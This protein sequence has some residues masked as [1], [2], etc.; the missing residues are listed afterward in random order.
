MPTIHRKMTGKYIKLYT[1]TL[2][3][4][5]ALNNILEDLK[6][7]FCT[8]APKN[9]RPIEVVIKG[10][11][12]D[13]NTSDIHSDLLDLRF[14]VNK[15]TQVTCNITKQLLPVF[16]ISLPRNLTNAKIFELKKLSFLSITVEGFESR[17]TT[18]CNQFNHTAEH[19]HLTPKCLKCGNE[20]QTRDCQIKRVDTPFCINCQ[21][22]GHMA[23]YTKCPLF[24]KPRK[25]ANI[26]TNYTNIV[27]SLVRPNT[28]YAQITHQTQIPDNRWHDCYRNTISKRN[29]HLDSH[30]HA[31]Q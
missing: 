19:C 1:D 20:H 6:Y 21:A 18:Q 4:Y 14:T 2:L 24:P 3:Q 28:S 27:N 11:P 15:V 16:T 17:E 10:L 12:R 5:H 8:I 9:E 29:S 26:K 22:Y 25:D 31:Q 30:S 7:P 13:M 23:N